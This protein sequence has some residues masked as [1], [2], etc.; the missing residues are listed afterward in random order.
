[1]SASEPA[2]IPVP[3]WTPLR[4]VAERR[5]HRHPRSIKRWE[6]DPRLNFPKHITIRGC[7]YY[8]A[9]ELDAW[10]IAQAGRLP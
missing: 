10:D 9:N 5:Y 3:R 6:T 2:S 1:M 4:D 7:R 8:D